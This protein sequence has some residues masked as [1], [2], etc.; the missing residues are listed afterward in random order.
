MLVS[1]DEVLHIARLARLTVREHEVAAIAA[2][3][4]AI[5]EHMNTLQDIPLSSPEIEAMGGTAP[6]R[7]DDLLNEHSTS[8]HVT[9]SPLV[10]DGFF[11]VPR[12]ETHGAES[13]DE[14][15]KES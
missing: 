9:F 15:D 3:L 14:D 1:R 4:G 6:L 11:L 8:E 5:L 10:R 13:S 2:E 12:L 7:D